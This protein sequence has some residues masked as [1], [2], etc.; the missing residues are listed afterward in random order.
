MTL[1]NPHEMG[2][3]RE[4]HSNFP[5]F[6]AFSPSTFPKQRVFAEATQYLVLYT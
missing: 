2:S 4:F 6:S 3:L 5:Y 1:L